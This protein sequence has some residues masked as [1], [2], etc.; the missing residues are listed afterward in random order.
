MELGVSESTARKFVE[1][2]GVRAFDAKSQNFLSSQKLD[3]YV[4]LT[5]LAILKPSLVDEQEGYR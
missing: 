4:M 3:K 1:Q 2:L 5:F